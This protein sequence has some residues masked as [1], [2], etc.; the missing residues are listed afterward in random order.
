MGN[1]RM[2]A[3]QV[4]EGAVKLYETFDWVGGLGCLASEAVN[5]VEAPCSFDSVRAKKLTIFGAIRRAGPNTTTDDW[6]TAVSW[7]KLYARQT[8]GYEGGTFELN[9]QEDMTKEKILEIL[10]KV[11]ERVKEHTVTQ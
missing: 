5:E 7:V 1:S 8:F 2:S 3:L 4:L 6:V 11:I 9:T 10:N